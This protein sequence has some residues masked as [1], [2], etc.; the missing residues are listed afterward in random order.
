MEIVNKFRNNLPYFHPKK[1][2]F[3]VKGEDLYSARV[4]RNI[5]IGDQSYP[6]N[7]QVRNLKGHLYS[8]GWNEAAMHYLEQH[9]GRANQMNDLRTPW[10]DTIP[11][12]SLDEAK[13]HVRNAMRLNARHSAEQEAFSVTENFDCKYF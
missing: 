13:Q 1:V 2:H 4:G 6:S 3:G 7:V 12:L 11:T 10:K 8:A 5:R 9:F